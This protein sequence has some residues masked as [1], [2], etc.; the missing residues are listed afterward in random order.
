MKRETE[1]FLP[2]QPFRYDRRVLAAAIRDWC[3]MQ[4][5]TSIRRRALIMMLAQQ[6]QQHGPTQD[7]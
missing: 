5:A 4:P 3:D 1:C 2:P 6:D 7:H